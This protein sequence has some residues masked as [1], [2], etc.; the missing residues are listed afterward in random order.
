M[1]S[2]VV[3]ERQRLPMGTQRFGIVP[4]ARLDV[5]GIFKGASLIRT[6]SDDGEERDRLL[7]QKQCIGGCALMLPYDGDIVERDRLGI[8]VAEFPQER[9]RL[10]VRAQRC[11][12][13]TEELL[14]VPEVAECSCLADRIAQFPVQRERPLVRS[15][16]GAVAA[17]I[18]LHVADVIDRARLFVRVTDLAE[19]YERRRV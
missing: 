2:E 5:A 14:R 17:L 18:G 3:V 9:V 15:K 4:Q 13:F 1:I 8:A 16:C 19:Q 6:V 10:P 7:V 12:V 11:R